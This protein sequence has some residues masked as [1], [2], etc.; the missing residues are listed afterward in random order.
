MNTIGSL[1]KETQLLVSFKVDSEEFAL[2]VASVKEIVK[3]TAITPVPGAPSSVQGIVNLRGNVL[4][5]IDLRKHFGLNEIDYTEESRIVVVQH[6]KG[7]L[8]IIVDKVSEVLNVGALDVE[9]PP[10]TLTESQRQSI[11]GLA[12]VNE[13]K[14]IILILNEGILLP[15]PPNYSGDFGLQSNT[16]ENNSNEVNANRNDAMRHLVTFQLGNEEFAV[17]ITN[18]KEIVRVT[19][20]TKTPDMP[21]YMEGIMPLRNVLVPVLNLK[22]K[23]SITKEDDYTVAEVRDDDFDYRRVIISDA[24]GVISGLLVDSVNEVIRVQES[25]IEATPSV[26]DESNAQFIEG[27]GKLNDGKRLILLLDLA[28]IISKKEHNNMITECSGETGGKVMDK[29]TRKDSVKQIVCFQVENE[30]FGIDIMQVREIIRITKIT[31]VP[32]TP[33]FVS[34]IVNLRGNVLP[35]I[36]LRIKFDKSSSER[37][38][39]N[40]ILVVDIEGKTTGLIVDSVSEVLRIYESNIEKPPTVLTAN[41][42]NKF[43]TGIGQLDDGKRSIMLMDTNKIITKEELTDVQAIEQPKENVSK[44]IMQDKKQESVDKKHLNTEK[45]SNDVEKL[46]EKTVEKSETK[47]SMQNIEIEK[48][49]LLKKSELIEL[50]EKNNIKIDSKMTK[51]QIIELLKKQ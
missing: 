43:I 26:I 39:Q 19:E 48:L 30:E 38:E 44:S 5:L 7:T 42:K 9:Q 6:A 24:N 12:K 32:K 15:D 50:A 4:S 35:V 3:I 13:G 22:T 16:A 34:G 17:D 29:E 28:K 45:Q 11:K 46:I 23:F 21:S 37:K 41:D 18:V 49:H 33:V 31:P 25:N 20:F 47:T 40:R 51:K 27:V 10:L 1:Q 14:K 36:D 8:G 2:P